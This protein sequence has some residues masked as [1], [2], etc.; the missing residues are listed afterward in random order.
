MVVN[1]LKE[2]EKNNIKIKTEVPLAR[3]TTLNIGGPAKYFVFVENEE[4]L[5]KVLKLAK[6]ASLDV[7]VIGAGSNILVSDNGFD[8]VVIKFKGTLSD[9]KIS[10]NKVISKAGAM[11]T[12]LIKLSVESSLAGLENLFGIPGSVG[13]AI[14][15]N[16]GAYSSTISDNLL[17]IEAIKL[18]E[19][20][21]GILRLDKKDIK[22]GY[23]YSNL[24]GFVITT[25]VFSLKEGNREKIKKRINKVLLE[26]SKTQPLGTFNAGCV[27]KNPQNGKISLAKLIEECGLKGYSCG[28]AYISLKHAN[29]IIN[30]NKATCEDFLNV[31][32]YVIKV[33]KEKYNII[34]EPEIKLIGVKL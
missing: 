28:D 30:K 21:K 1:F 3:Y 6:I 15:M 5:L 4:Q 23:R 22:F 25:A 31:M 2:V 12:S 13:G 16:A 7:L 19:L 29:F 27:F 20:E 18:D 24:E 9:I 34:I 8:G 17:Y 26:R 32:R 14:V 10:G 11:L 33:V